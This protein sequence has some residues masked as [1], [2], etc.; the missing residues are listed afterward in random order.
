[1]NQ[2]ELLFLSDLNLAESYRE[3]S[4][5][6]TNTDIAE[7]DDMLFVCGASTF[8]AVNF[9]IRVGRKPQ[10]PPELFISQAK[11][12]FAKRKR[13]FTITVRKHIDQDL[14]AKC[15]ELKLMKLA[16]IPGMFIKKTLEEKPLPDGVTLKHVTTKAMVNDYAE[17][18]ALS[19]TTLGMPEEASRS[20]F[21]NPNA[22]LVP[23]IYAVVA[24]K[25]NKPASCAFALLSHG[26]A[27]I[28]YVGTVETARGMGLAEHC[29]RAVG[30]T[31]FKFGARFV[32]LQAS[33]YGEPVYK[34]MGYQESTRYIRYLCRSR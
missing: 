6:S 32:I 25:D 13:S 28:Y 15:E 7:Q 30:N 12:F 9:A 20:I 29:V 26:I 17:V 2:D 19:F 18:V 24:Y 5:W 34:R 10:T 21:S 14:L 31:A 33:P 8:P 23:H 16:D 3:D 22:F 1:M 4:R 11:E 27:G